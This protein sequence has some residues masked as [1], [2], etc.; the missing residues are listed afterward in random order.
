MTAEPC[1]GNK[2]QSTGLLD[3]LLAQLV[4]SLLHSLPRAWGFFHIFCTAGSTAQPVSF[5]D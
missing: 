2:D 4:L 3:L 1:G 5:L